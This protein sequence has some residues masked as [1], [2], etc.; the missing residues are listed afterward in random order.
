MKRG[1]IQSS[2]RHEK[3]RTNVRRPFRKAKYYLVTD[4]EI[5]P[6]GKGEKDPGRGVKE[7]LK[8]YVYKQIE[9]IKVRY[10]T[11]CRTVRRVI[12][13]GEIKY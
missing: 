10:R 8:P 7:N 9:H 6:W 4:R 3:S 11:F 12:V 2:A 13:Y 1:S 5:V